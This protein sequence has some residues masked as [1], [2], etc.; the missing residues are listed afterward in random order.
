MNNIIFWIENIIL[1]KNDNEV[2]Y[3]I[4]NFDRVRYQLAYQYA[5]I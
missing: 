5:L 2:L 3:Q 1:R 4:S